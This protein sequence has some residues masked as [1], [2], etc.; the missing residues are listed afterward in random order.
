MRF[1]NIRHTSQIKN[2]FMKDIEISSK[3]QAITKEEAV[4][5]LRQYAELIFSAYDSAL[6]KYNVEI[7]Q[8]NPIA[9]TRLSSALLNAKMVESFADMF[10]DNVTLG[11]YGRVLFRYERCQLIIKKLSSTSRPS[12]ISTKLSNTILTQGQAELFDGDENARREP[13]LTFGYTKDRLGNLVNPRIVYFDEEPIWE[14][15]PSDFAVTLPFTDN[16]ER[17]EVRLKKKQRERKAE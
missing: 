3:R 13:L 1:L 4:E 5:L 2:Y 16:V 15:V 14:I 6:D 9:R 17:I 11:K 12:Y 10:P 7:R 8:T